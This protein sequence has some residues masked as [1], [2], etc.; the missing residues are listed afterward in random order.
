MRAAIRTLLLLGISQAISMGGLAWLGV[1]QDFPRAL[2][3]AAAVLYPLLFSLLPR[4]TGM[5]AEQMVRLTAITAALATTAVCVA[6]GG[7]ASPVLPLF[8]LLPSSAFA[9]GTRSLG[10][11][12]LLSATGLAIVAVVDLFG[13]VPEYTLAEVTDRAARV[14]VV[15][16][17]VLVAG[18]GALTA[19]AAR[20]HNRTTLIQARERAEAAAESRKSFLAMM[21]HEL[22]TPMTGI[23]GSVR[24]L[25]ATSL[26]DDQQALVK[27][28]QGS[29]SALHQV[30]NDIIDY[31]TRG[32]SET[33]SVMP[34]QPTDIHSILHECGELYTVAAESQNLTMDVD[35]DPK[36]PEY[37]IVEP[38][39]LRKLIRHGVSNAVKFTQVGRIHASAAWTEG[40][41]TITIRDTGPGMSEDHLKRIFEPFVQLS[42]GDQRSYGGAGLGLANARQLAEHLGGELTITSVLGE[43]TT[44]RIRVP[45][46]STIPPDPD[47][48]TKIPLHSGQDRRVL[49]IEDTAIVAE[50]LE[51]A[52]SQAGYSVVRAENGRAGLAEFNGGSFDLVLMDLHMPKMDGFAATQAIRSL[53]GA[54]AQVPVIAVTADLLPEQHERA[55]EAGVNEV[56]TKPVDFERLLRLAARLTHRPAS[57]A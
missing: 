41:L 24:L 21:S 36:M 42:S 22:R 33:E 46:P 35:I 31:A 55:F 7:V 9:T 54:A 29:G 48:E 51:R 13:W 53:P 6:T 39:A 5:S 19:E 28:L 8:V 27:Q 3:F 16:H 10:R 17:S 49:V 23:L 52:L 1:V 56:I 32:A 4:L 50:I 43:G 45:A 37:V 47:S 40:M 57:Q 2:L 18:F 11:L 30:L 26:D 44:F 15:G 38:A 12:A 20:E 34:P 25:R 14:L